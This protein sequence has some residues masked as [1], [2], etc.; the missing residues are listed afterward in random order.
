MVSAGISFFKIKNEF[1]EQRLISIKSGIP[2]FIFSLFYLS[3]VIYMIPIV[4]V[5]VLQTKAYM[6]NW[7]PFIVI[8]TYSPGIIL[9]EIIV[10]KLECGYDYQRKAT[11]KI[12]EV[13][14]LGWT[15]M[16][17]YMVLW[18]IFNFFVE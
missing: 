8:L 6:T 13:A 14:Y 7:F 3:L 15:A 4:I 1:K 12:K 18:I 9:S 16:I 2:S 11:K 5:N 10:S 17:L